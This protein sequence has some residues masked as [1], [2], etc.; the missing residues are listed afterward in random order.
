MGV[1]LIYIS[2]MSHD[3]EPPFFFFSFGTS[4]HVLTGNLYIFFLKMRVLLLMSYK[5]SLS[6]WMP[7]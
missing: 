7:V 6:I 4:F 5:S 1:V 3:V 2:P